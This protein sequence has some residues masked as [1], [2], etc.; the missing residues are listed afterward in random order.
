VL[1]LRRIGMAVAAGQSDAA[2]AEGAQMTAA[3]EA[4]LP[5]LQAALP[6]SLFNPALREAHYAA[7][8]QLQLTASRASN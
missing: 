5:D 1:Q 7:L 3:L 4:A 8:R 2:V 6:W